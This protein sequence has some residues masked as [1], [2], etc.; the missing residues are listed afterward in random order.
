LLLLRAYKKG[1]DG[2]FV[3][4]KL[5]AICDEHDHGPVATTSVSVDIPPDTVDVTDAFYPFEPG[6]TNSQ[7][8]GI[9]R[10]RTNSQ[11]LT[12]S[13]LLPPPTGSRHTLLREAFGSNALSRAEILVDI[14]TISSVMAV[15][16]KLAASTLPWTIRIPAIYF[17]VGWAVIQALLVLH[18]Y[19]DLDSGTQMNDIVNEARRLIN[20]MPIRGTGIL[21]NNPAFYSSFPTI[22]YLSVLPIAHF[23]LSTTFHLQASDVFVDE[24]RPYY[25]VLVL[26]S[27]LAIKKWT[28]AA[29]ETP[30]R[31]ALLGIAGLAFPDRFSHL[32]AGMF[33]ACI[34]LAIFFAP[35]STWESS[36]LAGFLTHFVRSLH[37]VVTG[38]AFYYLV[39]FY[40]P[41]GTSKP[42]WLDWLG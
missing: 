3:V 40:N 2:V 28:R 8:L 12:S 17:L 16:L 13:S 36:R 18:H 41:Q 33:G 9:A 21:L 1:D 31:L 5:L 34:L 35:T 29:E 25:I 10:R 14:V 6:N 30:L 39:A 22:L 32:M 7:H 38:L 19:K 20:R 27:I 11:F 23:R 26:M 42:G 24:I 37:L 15:I 4:D